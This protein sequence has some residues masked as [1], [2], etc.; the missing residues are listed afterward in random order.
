[1]NFIKT[2]AAIAAIQ[3]LLASHDGSKA[4]V[5][6]G[7]KLAQSSANSDGT[8]ASSANKSDTTGSIIPDFVLQTLFKRIELAAEAFHTELLKEQD[9]IDHLIYAAGFFSQLNFWF[10]QIRSLNGGELVS[11]ELY[12]LEAATNALVLKTK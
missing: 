9:Y 7:A 12:E 3:E 2:R 11:D 8:G 1:M 5:A 10:R 4:L 6:Y